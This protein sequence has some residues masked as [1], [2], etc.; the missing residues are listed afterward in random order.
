MTRSLILRLLLRL[1]PRHLGTRLGRA[2]PAAKRISGDRTNARDE[3]RKVKEIPFGTLVLCVNFLFDFMAFFP[4]RLFDIARS[5]DREG[6][7]PR[8]FFLYVL[9]NSCTYCILFS[10]CTFRAQ[11]V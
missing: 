11:L 6:I 8:K 10:C 3:N 5:Y 1:L 9:Q 4:G 7:S 2:G